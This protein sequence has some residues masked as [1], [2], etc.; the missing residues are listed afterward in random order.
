MDISD[1]HSSIEEK[2]VE[3][4]LFVVRD[5]KRFFEGKSQIPFILSLLTQIDR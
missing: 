5:D 2:L 4:I 3:R 1:L